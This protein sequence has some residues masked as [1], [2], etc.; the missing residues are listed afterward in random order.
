MLNIKAWMLG[1]LISAMALAGCATPVPTPAILSAADSARMI[2][3]TVTTH[4]QAV[5]AVEIAAT[6]AAIHPGH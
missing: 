1:V 2:K 6:Y 5:E 3:V 4:K